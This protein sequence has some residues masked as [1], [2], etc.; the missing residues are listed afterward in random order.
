MIKIVLIIFYLNFDNEIF[1]KFNDIDIA[2]SRSGAS[3]IF[4][5]ARYLKFL[6]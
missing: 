2:I 4:E 5:L 3:T 6:L 1:D